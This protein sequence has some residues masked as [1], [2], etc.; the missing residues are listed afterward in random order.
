MYTSKR[1]YLKDIIIGQFQKLMGWCPNA[2]QHR[3][4]RTAPAQ[5]ASI[6]GDRGG[7]LPALP[8][9]RMNRY[10]T[11][12]FVFALCMTGV[13]IT[14]FATATGDRPAMLL[15]GLALAAILYFG[16][17]LRYRDLFRQVEQA[18]VVNEKNWTEISV[19]RI[20]PIIGTA[21][22][23]AFAGAVLLGL[24]PGLSMRAINGFLA[25]FAAIGWL[26][27]LTILAWE[28]K[29]G[30]ALFTDGDRIYRGA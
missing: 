20:L 3:I 13:G 12:T 27:L 23:L 5:P 9:G 16:D 4:C 28:Q 2:G 15:T 18:G 19:V 26:H 17:A 24:I 8:F 10:R 11:R 1:A 14:L 25:G 6:P 29:S 22:I 7:D 21:L 30:I